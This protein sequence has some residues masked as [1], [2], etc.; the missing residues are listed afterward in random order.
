MRT[1]GGIHWGMETA[2]TSSLNAETANALADMI[3][4]LCEF[5]IQRPTLRVIDGG[6]TEAATQ[7]EAS[8]YGNK[9]DKD[10]NVVEIAKRIRADIKQ[11]IADGVIP[12]IKTSVRI[13]RYSMGRSIDI[14]ITEAPFVVVNPE[15]T[16]ARASGASVREMDGIGQLTA[17]AKRVRAVV[18]D[19]RAAYNYDRSDSMTDYYDVNFGGSVSYAWEMLR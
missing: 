15:W 5:E 4:S 1:G 16:A 7:E 12:A 3:G 19:I 18:A 14:Y 10:L 17:E 2:I 11:V 9:Y 6:K 13:S 8:P